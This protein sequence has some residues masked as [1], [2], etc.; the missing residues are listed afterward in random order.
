MKKDGHTAGLLIATFIGGMVA[1][2]ILAIESHPAWQIALS[3]VLGILPMIVF[4]A[5]A[6]C[7]ARAALKE[8]DT[9]GFDK[10]ECTVKSCDVSICKNTRSSFS[11]PAVYKLTA[12]AANGK[13]YVA[14]SKRSYA[15]GSTIELFV[16]K[17]GK[18]VRIAEQVVKAREIYDKSEEK[19]RE[20]SEALIETCDD[21][22]CNMI[23]DAWDA[24]CDKLDKYD[25]S[26]E[27][28]QAGY[29][30]AVKY[31]KLLE[32]FAD[33]KNADGLIHISPEQMTEFLREYAAPAN[34]IDDEKSELEDIDD[35]QTE[36]AGNDDRKETSAT[37]NK[38]EGSAE[39]SA[40]T[41]G[42][43]SRETPPNGS[44]KPKPTVGYKGIRVKK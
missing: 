17:S 38:A 9:T 35:G 13:T 11:E 34:D 39:Q 26:Y 24:E 7:K 6:M 30:I 43:E 8:I 2:V 12:A 20:L 19:E 31:V 27:R 37:E 36:P 40:G 23:T 29:D 3:V 44:D 16:D 1:A 21:E 14:Y 42:G 25:Y 33:E 18:R 28:L 41:D 15:C 4:F 32:W 10:I 22:T 5:V